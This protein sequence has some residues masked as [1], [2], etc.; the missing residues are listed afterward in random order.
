MMPAIEGA[1]APAAPAA[2]SNPVYL[3]EPRGATFLAAVVCFFVP[4]VHHYHTIN[5]AHCSLDIAARPAKKQTSHL[6]RHHFITHFPL[7][8]NPSESKLELDISDHII[9]LTH[10][11]VSCSLGQRGSLTFSHSKRSKQYL[12]PAAPILKSQRHQRTTFSFLPG[13]W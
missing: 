6:H 5:L 12:D 3:I 9:L 1:A 13:F 10:R 8:L 4:F 2:P 7:A 11:P